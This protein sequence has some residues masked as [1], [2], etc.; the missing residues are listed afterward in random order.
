MVLIVLRSLQISLP[1]LIL[2]GQHRSA[3]TKCK[4][5]SLMLR[6][7]AF[8]MLMLSEGSL[9]VVLLLEL[10]L[11]LEVR[12]VILSTL[13]RGSELDVSALHLRQGRVEVDW[14]HLEVFL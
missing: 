6:L 14:F 4:E 10:G 2:L 8:L 1:L 11:A 9:F 13:H 3:I 5:L 12:K 7:K